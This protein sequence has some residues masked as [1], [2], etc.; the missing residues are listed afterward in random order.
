MNDYVQGLAEAFLG[1]NPDPQFIADMADGNWFDAE[2]VEYV[3]KAM[4]ADVS[5]YKVYQAWDR[6][7]RPDYGQY[8]PCDYNAWG[9]GGGGP[10]YRRGQTAEARVGAVAAIVADALIELVIALVEDGGWEAVPC[11]VCN[12]QPGWFTDA[13]HLFGLE[14]QSGYLVPPLS[15]RG[16]E[17]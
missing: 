15:E 13:G 12:D 10:G 7:G 11:T 2:V 16:R 4:G 3:G 17:L 1:D 8:L 6:A 14:T 5:P 9:G